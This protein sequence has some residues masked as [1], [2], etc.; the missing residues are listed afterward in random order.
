MVHLEIFLVFE[1]RSDGLR[2]KVKD[3]PTISY[4]S[5]ADRHRTTGLP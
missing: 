3:F 2:F 5:G 4:R 1:V